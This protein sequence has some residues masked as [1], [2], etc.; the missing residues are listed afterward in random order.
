MS[1]SRN[2]RTVSPR[3]LRREVPSTVALLADGDDF[4]AMRRYTTFAFADH[5]E[6]LERMHQLM[7]SLTAQGIHVT[8]TLFDPAEYAHY[9][10]D[11]GQEPD[12]PATRTRYTAEVAALGAAVRYRG[13]PV[14]RLIAELVTESGRR[15]T[16]ERATQL[17]ARDG[18][19]ERC[20]RCGDG[21]SRK[22][23]DMFERASHALMRLLESVGSGI[24]HIVCSIPAEQQQLIGVLHAECDQH[25]S[26]RLAESEALVFCT[27]LAAGMAIDSPG[28]VV[29][30]TSRP[31]EPDRVRGWTLRDGR[32]QPLTEAEVF[33]A[34]C[35]DADTGEP[36]PPEPG[37]VYSAGTD[38]PPCTPDAP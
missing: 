30:R 13:Q 6:Y 8:A 1:R 31:D 25:G 5:D 23:H 10:E 24:H 12:T 2:H 20:E 36:V 4:A 37:V 19:F 34:Y 11:T 33:N 7:R 38:I 22:P 27:V 18:R 21:S 28:G 26:V 29:M 3:A 17:L 16:W 35:T 15:A 14:G 32:L 9:C